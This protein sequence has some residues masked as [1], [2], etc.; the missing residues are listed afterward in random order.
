MIKMVKIFGE[1]SKQFKIPITVDCINKDESVFQ[2]FESDEYD[3]F[4][5]E[6]E[7]ESKFDNITFTFRHS[8]FLTI[9]FREIPMKIGYCLNEKT[10]LI[11]DSF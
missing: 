6:D 7:F 4:I 2:V 10:F 11:I 3:I 8:S 5:H 1:L 9:F